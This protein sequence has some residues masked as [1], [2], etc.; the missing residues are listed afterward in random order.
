[1][2]VLEEYPTEE[3]CCVFLAGKRPQMQRMFIKKCFLFTAGSVCR[4]K[5]FTTESRNSLKDV[6]NSQIMADYVALL[7]LRQMQLCNRWKS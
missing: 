6:R 1:M 5:G 4:V 2:T 7:R 3:Q